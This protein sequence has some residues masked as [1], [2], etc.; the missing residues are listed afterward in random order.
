VCVTVILQQAINVCVCV[1]VCVCV[2]PYEQDIHMNVPY[3]CHIWMSHMNVSYKC[4]RLER[5]S[6]TW[7][8]PANEPCYSKIPQQRFESWCIFIHVFIFIHVCIHSYE[9]VCM[10]AYHL[11][12]LIWIRCSCVD[13]RKTR[14]NFCASY[15]V[16]TS[17]VAHGWVGDNSSCH[18]CIIV[19]HN[20][21]PHEKLLGI[22][23]VSNPS[24]SIDP[25]SLKIGFLVLIQNAGFVRDNGTN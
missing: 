4:L 9:Y 6:S 17:H 11:R 23:R 5:N 25:G 16:W 24:T 20:N 1:C 19:R 18:T 10:N 14:E 8:Q 2:Y 3:E 15:L 21:V 7:D 12:V 22:K 13:Q